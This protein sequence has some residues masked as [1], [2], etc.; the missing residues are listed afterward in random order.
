MAKHQTRRSVSLSG[1]TYA[2]ISARAAAANVSL[3]SLVER[4]IAAE[5]RRCS[6]VE[7]AFWCG[8]QAGETG[9][10]GRHVDVVAKAVKA[11]ERAGER[12]VE[13]IA[14]KVRAIPAESRIVAGPPP[15]QTTMLGRTPTPPADP[16]R[17][18]DPAPATAPGRPAPQRV[19]TVAA[20]APITKADPLAGV[21]SGRGGEVSF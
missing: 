15:E 2:A 20:P 17:G 7:G 13:R 3:S 18:V 21:R 14:E 19:A 9:R 12:Q 1:P 8:A 16:V 5:L 10:C 4:A 6:Y 11:I